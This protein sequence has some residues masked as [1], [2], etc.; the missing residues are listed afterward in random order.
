MS[1]RR[2]RSYDEQTRLGALEL[3]EEIGPMKA[4]RELGILPQR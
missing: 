3:A 2:T 4:A 1:R